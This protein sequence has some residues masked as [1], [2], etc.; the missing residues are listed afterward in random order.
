MGEMEVIIDFV[1]I[2]P[3]LLTV[4]I[5]QQAW[6]SYSFTGP[7]SIKVLMAVG[8]HHPILN[9]HSDCSSI[10]FHSKCLCGGAATIWRDWKPVKTSVLFASLCHQNYL[11]ILR[12]C[13]TQEEPVAHMKSPALSLLLSLSSWLPLITRLDRSQTKPAGIPGS[14]YWSGLTQWVKRH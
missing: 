3:F 5:L 9:W 13:L 8:H 11:L 1:L 10:Y 7:I 4:K 12:S 6:K 14:I 2:Q